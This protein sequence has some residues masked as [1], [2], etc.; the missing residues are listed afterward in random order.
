MDCE[1][2]QRE[3]VPF[4]F[5]TVEPASRA[6]LEG[7]LLG[8]PGCMKDY[9]TLKR[10][11]ETGA[12]APAP[13]PEARDRLRRAVAQELERRNPRRA[14]RCVARSRNTAMKASCS[15]SS[16]S[17]GSSSCLHRKPYRWRS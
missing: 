17:C 13:R 8:C 15:M 1:L 2:S 12:T 5:G 10:D 11:I 4:H 6:A 14:W 9:L 16:A 3:L 7:H